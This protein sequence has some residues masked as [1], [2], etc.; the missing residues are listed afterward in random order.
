MN[1]GRGH[2]HYCIL[3]VLILVCLCVCVGVKS[4][5]IDVETQQVLVECTLP[6]AEVLAMIENTGRRAVLKGIG[7]SEQGLCVC[8][9]VCVCV[10][11]SRK[12]VATDAFLWFFLL[13]V[14]CTL[15]GLYVIIMLSLSVCHHMLSLY[16]IIAD[17]IT[18]HTT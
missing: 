15:I 3:V 2:L 5:S 11:F 10:I 16:A 7:G 13:P 14:S 8:V 4:F 6:V 9:C 17:C 18:V 1:M 12:H